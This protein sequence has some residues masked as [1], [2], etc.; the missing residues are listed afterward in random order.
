MDQQDALTTS[1]YSQLFEEAIANECITLCP[2]IQ[3]T[4]AKESRRD[5]FYWYWIGRDNNGT[6][7]RVYIGPENKDTEELIASLK[8]RKDMAKQAIE[9]MKRTSAAYRG[10][11]GQ[12]NEPSHFKIISLLAR[13]GLFQKGV[14]IIGSHG[15]LSICNALGISA[16]TPFLRTTDIDFARPQGISLAIP[17]ERKALLDIPAALKAIDKNFFL[18]PRLDEKNPSTSMQNNKSKVKVDFLTAYRGSKEPV[19]FDDLGIAAEPLRF[20]DFLLAGEPLKG[21]IIGSYAIPVNLP[22]PARFAIHKLIISQERPYHF[23]AKSQ[24]DIAQA[25]IL[26]D[27]LVHEDAEQIIDALLACLTTE[28]AV[29]NIKKTLPELNRIN[30]LLSDFIAAHLK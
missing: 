6:A 7:R 4:F 9:G 2:G 26:L 19:F 8:N 12:I 27:Y 11:G 22:S 16:S 10:A 5:T 30:G 15:F 25:A 13:Q 14:F 20:M 28:D 18:D 3:G 23:V 21:L 1:L 24:K 17:D 29:K